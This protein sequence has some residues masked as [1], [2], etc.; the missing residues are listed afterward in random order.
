MFADLPL[1]LEVDLDPEYG[2]TTIYIRRPD[3]RIIE[4][5]PVMC[6][7]A[8]NETKILQ[9]LQEGVNRGA[10]RHSEEVFLSYGRYGFYFDQPGEYL[11]R[12]LYQGPGDVLIPS[13]VHRVRV[14]TPL[15]KDQD[16]IAQDYFSYQVGMSLYLNG[17]RSPF[18]SKGMDLLQDVASRYEDSMAGAKIAQRVAPSMA[19]PFFRLQ[20]RGAGDFA[21]TKTHDADPSQVVTLT[22]S[23]LDVYRKEPVKALNLGYHELVRTRT[24][25]L[26]ELGENNRAKKE[27]KT[28]QEDLRD[29]GANEPV[30]KQINQYEQSISA[31]TASPSRSSKPVGAGKG[32]ATKSGKS[33]RK[34]KGSRK[35]SR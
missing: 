26:L 29:R 24:E 10:D 25:C 32:G 20:E 15:T 17:S 3:G 5:A 22:E 19:Q 35:S 34:R 2:G 7:L 27:L 1:N 33:S 28:L 31:S 23:A 13:N 18:L 4:Y 21:L 14:G 16:R 8:A 12:A 9:P 30:L 6:K 11:V